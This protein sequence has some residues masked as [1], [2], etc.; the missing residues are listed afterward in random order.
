M[1]PVFR[2]TEKLP[3]VEEVQTEA[4]EKKESR[5]QS[6]VAGQEQSCDKKPADHSKHSLRKGWDRQDAVRLASIVPQ[7]AML[8]LRHTG[9]LEQPVEVRG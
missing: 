8:L 7:T 1:T 3:E 5:C 2:I 9:T 4:R 6:C